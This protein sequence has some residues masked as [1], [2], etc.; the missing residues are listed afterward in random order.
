[1]IQL[2]LAALTA[3]GRAHWSAQLAAVE[4]LAG[5]ARGRRSSA[6]RS[7]GLKLSALA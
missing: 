6:G 3:G 4:T 7:A 5:G 1:M 2:S